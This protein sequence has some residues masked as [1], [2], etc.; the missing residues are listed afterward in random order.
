MHVGLF[1]AVRHVRDWALHFYTEYVS[2]TL[3]SLR[4]YQLFYEKKSYTYAV[5]RW[6]SHRSY[7]VGVSAPRFSD[8]QRRALWSLFCASV[9]RRQI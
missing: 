3:W 9:Y 2:D 5:S 7:F 6:E 4:A 8:R 1:F